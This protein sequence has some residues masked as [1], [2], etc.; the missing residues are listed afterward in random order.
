[1]PIVL[2]CQYYVLR[3]GQ[4]RAMSPRSSMTTE[5]KRSKKS[6]VAKNTALSSEQRFS[7]AEETIEINDN[8]LIDAETEPS[9]ADIFALD[10]E[11]RSAVAS[12]VSH[13][14]QRSAEPL[15]P[16]PIHSKRY[17]LSEA[18]D[19]TQMYLREIG[20]AA[21]LSADEEKQLA[22]L[23]QQ[24]DEKARHRMIESNLRLVV[25]IAKSYFNRGLPFIDIIAEGNMGLM[26]AVSKFDPDRGFR[27][28][29]YSTW[30]IRQS[31]E[32]ALMNQVRTIR[33]PIH[34][35]KEMNIYLRAARQLSQRLDHKPT[36]E[37]IAELVD[38][39]LEDVK[40]LLG[41]KEDATSY[42][43][44]MNEEGYTNLSEIIPDSQEYSNPVENLHNERLSAQLQRLL[45]ELN[46]TQSEIIMRRFGLGK[47][48]EK[49]T[50]DTVG[51]AMG[52]TRERVR[53]IQLDCL[54]Q[55]HRR[56]L[57]LGMTSDALLE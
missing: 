57:E 55:L 9:S 29:T 23:A 16:P 52:L 39:P 21:L 27:F 7:P 14:S 48:D 54:K 13:Q 44:I 43:G 42:D 53:Q 38:K 26:H 24:G 22:R 33:L 12:F 31:I 32:S 50:L 5:R 46:H 49:Q 45:S 2:A 25:K 56:M 4:D 17:T 34:V 47:Y 51:A 11:E 8:Q 10:E 15:I 41:Y 20:Y 6:T 37:E 28:S 3:T 40:A 19:A 35:I 30:W 36:Y 1:M 18:L